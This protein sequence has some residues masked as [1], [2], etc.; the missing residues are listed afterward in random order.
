M[1]FRNTSLSHLTNL[2]LDV[3]KIDRSYIMQLESNPKLVDSIL[4]LAEAFS[5]RVIA[6]G[7]ETIEQL[8]LL[9][10]KKCHMAQG[11]LLSKPISEAELIDLLLKE[12]GV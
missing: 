8:R 1:R 12:A 7:V 3:L 9:E 4:Q 10:Q 2:Q 5:L 11:F 6:E